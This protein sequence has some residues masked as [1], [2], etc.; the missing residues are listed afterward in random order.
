MSDT[1]QPSEVQFL[2]QTRLFCW[3]HA[4]RGKENCFREQSN[5]TPHCLHELFRQHDF[6]N[7]KRVVFFFP[8]PRPFFK[9]KT[10]AGLYI[11]GKV[12]QRWEWI[13]FFLPLSL[14]LW[15]CVVTS[16]LWGTVRAGSCLSGRCCCCC[17]W[18]HLKLSNLGS[19]QDPYARWCVFVWKN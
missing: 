14:P 8:R 16:E 7:P 13:D 19:N 10:E 4:G 5:S 11:S 12:Q 17:F 1:S 9:L 18:Y 15:K 2:A 6:N 3:P